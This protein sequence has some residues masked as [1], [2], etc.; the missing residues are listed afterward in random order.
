MWYGTFLI[1]FKN[2][3]FTVL[4]KAIQS[5]YNESCLNIS[6]C[7]TN[8]NLSCL[9]QTCICSPTTFWSSLNKSCGK[10]IN[11]YKLKFLL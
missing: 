11:F 4:F 1:L 2:I 10:K 9:N 5:I 8:S 3:L 6:G 7:L